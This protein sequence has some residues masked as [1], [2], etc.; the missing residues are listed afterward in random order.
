MPHSKILFALS[1]LISLPTSA[2]Q[3]RP[4]PN[5]E[6]GLGGAAIMHS[7]TYSSDATPL[8]GPLGNGS[9]SVKS[10]SIA[11]AAACPTSLIRSDGNALVL[12]TNMFGLNPVVQIL[13]KKTGLSMAKLTRRQYS[14][15]GIRVFG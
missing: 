6:V 4:I 2:S 15:W 3:P 9:S 14:G 7:D 13:N 1:F 8:V 12:C 10:K 11:L 5:P